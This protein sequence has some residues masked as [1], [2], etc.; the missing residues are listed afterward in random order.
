MAAMTWVINKVILKII[1]HL[2]WTINL[3]YYPWV[4][5]LLFASGWNIKQHGCVYGTMLYQHFLYASQSS[6]LALLEPIL[7]L[8]PDFTLSIHDTPPLICGTQRR[9]DRAAFVIIRDIQLFQ[10]RIPLL[11]SELAE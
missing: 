8:T 7:H 6:G 3:Q 10:C 11:I 2:A 1:R 9:S 4:L 5:P